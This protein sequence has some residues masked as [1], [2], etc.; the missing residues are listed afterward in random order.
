MLAVLVGVPGLA[1]VCATA[2][3]VPHSEAPESLAAACHASN[4][5]AQRLSGDT[6]NHCGVHQAAAA[7]S[8]ARLQSS[9]DDDVPVAAL[10]SAA[11][12]VTTPHLSI[13]PSA[14]TPRPTPAGPSRPPLVI[15][16]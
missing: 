8:A 9:R 5:P 13:R 14:V 3:A 7:E 12:S 2:C 1:A 11:H 15:R 10:L 6:A 4:E 16:V